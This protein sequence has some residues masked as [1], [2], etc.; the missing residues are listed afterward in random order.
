MIFKFLIVYFYHKYFNTN[1]IL[2]LSFI[3]FTKSIQP[4]S[5]VC[6]YI[7]DFQII[8]NSFERSLLQSIDCTKRF[9]IQY[10]FTFVWFKR[11]CCK[12]C[13]KKFF[14][15][16]LHKQKT[17]Y[18]IVII[19]F[20]FSF[21]EVVIRLSSYLNVFRILIW[22]LQTSGLLTITCNYLMN[23]VFGLFTHY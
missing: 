16:L 7:F 5:L 19:F 11:H 22:I 3:Q 18:L 20:L 9:F 14:R 10:L 15:F 4:R 2:P 12:N 1:L 6:Q 23:Y 8:L 17:F 13:I 21:W